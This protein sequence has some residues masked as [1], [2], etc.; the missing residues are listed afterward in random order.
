M[1]KQWI[2]M[3]RDV[4]ILSKKCRTGSK[5][6]F[7]PDPDS[8]LKIKT[9]SSFTHPHVS[10][11]INILKNAENKAALDSIGFYC[12]DKKNISQNIIL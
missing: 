12:I 8:S 3:C 6:L 1:H 5:E 10:H 11:K 4:F 2:W 9:L 7:L